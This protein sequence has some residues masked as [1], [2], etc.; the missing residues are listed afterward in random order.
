GQQ[1]E[2]VQEVATK[3]AEQKKVNSNFDPQFTCSNLVKLIEGNLVAER[4]TPV[5]QDDEPEVEADEEEEEEDEVEGEEVANILDVIKARN[6][7]STFNRIVESDDT[8][9]QALQRLDGAT[10]FVPDDDAFHR[11]EVSSGTTINA[12]INDE[13]KIAVMLN[14][15]S[16][17]QPFGEEDI[18]RVPSSSIT[19]EGSQVLIGARKY[20]PAKILESYATANGFLHVI[21]TVIDSPDGLKEQVAKPPASK[22]A[23]KSPSKTKVAPATKS[24]GRYVGKAKVGEL[25]E[26]LASKV[27]QA[28]SSSSSKND[29]NEEADEDVPKPATKSTKAKTS[30]KI[31]LVDYLKKNQDLVGSMIFFEKMSKFDLTKPFTFFAPTDEAWINFTGI[32]Q[33]KMRDTISDYIKSVGEDDAEDV[34]MGHFANAKYDKKDLAQLAAKNQSIEMANVE[35]DDRA[36][37][38]TSKGELQIN[39]IDI[40]ASDEVEGGVV[41][42]IDQVIAPQAAGDDEA[43]EEEE[44]GEAAASPSVESDDGEEDVESDDKDEEEENDSPVVSTKPSK[45]KTAK[46]TAKAEEV[47]DEL[48]DL[49]GS[50][51]LFK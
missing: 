14:V 50:R 15:L 25:P 5:I 41:H 10:L 2:F 12:L 33:P 3:L 16:V 31:T 51:E 11:Y 21:D 17:A 27:K 45:A 6:T 18:T 1:K 42:I 36:I 28:A 7:L 19:S 35:K 4:P 37:T 39:S 24:T 47:D 40:I 48:A 32:E 49:F 38:A 13:A 20:G 34:L 44:D 30:G 43:S 46:T 9:I 8:A 23:A 29:E 26:G 22:P